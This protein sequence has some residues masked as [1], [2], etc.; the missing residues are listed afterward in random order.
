MPAMIVQLSTWILAAALAQ[1]GPEAGWLKAVPGD[2]DVV[3]RTRG[4]EATRDDVA[5]ML[6]A[7]SPSLADAA[8]PALEDGLGHVRE[9]FGAALVQAPCVVLARVVPPGAGG[10]MPVA[11]VVLKDDYPGL[12]KSLAGENPA[13]SR[14]G[15]YDE[16]TSAKV[17][18]T[19]YGAKG[20]GF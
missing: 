8:R 20:A 19:W 16:F 12:R 5:A 11:V 13:K 7:M 17:P 3:I 18:G 9:M 14:D 10:G 1:G 15:G 4:L 2:I 6:K